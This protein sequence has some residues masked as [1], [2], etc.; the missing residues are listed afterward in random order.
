MATEAEIR[1]QRAQQAKESAMRQRSATKSPMKSSGGGAW[2][3]PDP[4]FDNPNAHGPTAP[5]PSGGMGGLA[6]DYEPQPERAQRK[7]FG[8]SEGDQ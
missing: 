5:L 2:A 1:V 7:S 6:K 4:T 3:K 8:V